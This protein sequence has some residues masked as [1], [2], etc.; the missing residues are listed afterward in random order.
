MLT[1][2]SP[3]LSAEVMSVDACVVSPSSSFPVR[4]VLPWGVSSPHLRDRRRAESCVSR[5]ARPSRR[6]G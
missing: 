6:S 5:G 3:F 1:G 4:A 2:C